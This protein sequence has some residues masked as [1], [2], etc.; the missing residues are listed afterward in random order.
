MNLKT[1]I[2]ISLLV[3]LECE[4][5]RVTGKVQFLELDIEHSVIG[6]TIKNG[7]EK[8]LDE[9]KEKIAALKSNKYEGKCTELHE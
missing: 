5:Y 1:C 4:F 7:M 3:R 6:P 9:K 2:Y 8:N